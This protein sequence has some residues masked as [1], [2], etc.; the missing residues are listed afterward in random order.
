M[1]YEDCLKYAGAKVLA[2]KYF[3]SYQGDWIAK[4]YYNG[5][6]GWVK[7]YFGS[8]SGCD[9]FQAEFSNIYHSDDDDVI[10]D[11]FYKGFENGCKQCDEIKQRV[12]DFGKSYLSGMMTYDA[13]LKDCS[14]DTDW[15]M[16]ADEI[17]KFIKENG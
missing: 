17:V 2:F 12:I 8:C 6:I 4:V 13:I 14:R 7:D 11:P 9:A 5:E 3:G 10:H 1:D 15:D 16:E